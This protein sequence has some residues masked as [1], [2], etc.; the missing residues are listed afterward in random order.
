MRFRRAI[1]VTLFSE[2]YESSAAFASAVE[3]W[4]AQPIYSTHFPLNVL[5]HHRASRLQVVDIHPP[6]RGKAEGLRVLEEHYGVPA[7]R[8]VAVG[9]ATNDIPMFEAAGLA[10][11]MGDGMPEAVAAADRVIGNV[12]TDAI[13]ALVEEL[14]LA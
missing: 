2:T 10:V 5:A 3:A 9:D 8:V 12:G 6:C 7:S 13:G 4:I 11:A 14:F 1:R